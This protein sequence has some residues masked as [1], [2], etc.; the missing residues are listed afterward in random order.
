[1]R[2][3]SA[4]HLSSYNSLGILYRDSSLTL[5]YQD[6]SYD[7]CCAEEQEYDQCDDAHGSFHEFAP[8]FL[9][10]GRKS[11]DDAREDDQRNTITDAVLIDLLTEP[12]EERRTGCQHQDD[13]DD[14]ECVC[15]D[16]GLS[17][18]TD[19]H[20]DCLYNCQ[21]NCKVSCVLCYLLSSFCSLS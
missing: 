16:E 11:R 10:R 21:S 19:G 15:A 14:R 3:L 1:M 7:D 5:L 20:A 17:E 4:V 18:Q 8:D 6:D 12:H 2:G 9:A 13:H